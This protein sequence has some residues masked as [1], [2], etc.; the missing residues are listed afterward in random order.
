MVCQQGVGECMCMYNNINT[1]SA[2]I[3][4]LYFI[5]FLNIMHVCTIRISMASDI[6][7]HPVMCKSGSPLSVFLLLLLP[8]FASKTRVNSLREIGQILDKYISGYK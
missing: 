3:Y 6:N 7:G 1:H 2:H 4:T 5:R 8:H